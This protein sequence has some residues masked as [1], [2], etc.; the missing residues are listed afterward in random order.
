[1][2]AKARQLGMTRTTFKNASGLTA[3]GHLSTPRDMARLG[4][5]LF[6]DFPQYYNIFS[7]RSDR[8]AGKRIYTTNRLLSSYPGADG[9]KTGFTNAAGY[10]LVAS[11]H[12]G[13]KR[14]VAAIFGGRSS[15][16]RNAQMVKLLDKGFA[17]ADTR[18][19]MIRPRAGRTLV[20]EAPVPEPRPDAPESGFEALAGI[21]T[22]EAQA[23]VV[24]DSPF[25]PERALTPPARPG[26]SHTAGG[27][28]MPVARPA[29]TVRLGSFKNHEIAVARLNEVLLADLG[30]LA[31]A[32]PVIDEI[33]SNKGVALYRVSL[34]GLSES[35]AN[36]TCRTLKAGG[37][38]CETVATGG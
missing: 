8:A 36:Q 14:I 15:R 4:R 13:H 10:N 20:A 7:R 9:I 29:W 31:D 22:S 32:A 1:M 18:V 35:N 19:A 17:Q 24:A 11:A 5:H 27:I 33:R 34:G 26:P 6:F 2:T 38:S 37:R 30:T 28:P 12:R 23:A 25:A 3:R 16:S 21:L